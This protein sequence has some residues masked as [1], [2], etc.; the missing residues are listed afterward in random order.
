MGVAQAR[1]QARSSI[2]EQAVFRTAQHQFRTDL[3][4]RLDGHRPVLAVADTGPGIPSAEMGNVLKPFYRLEASRTT[5]GS[6]LGL[7]LVAAI[8]KQHRAELEAVPDCT[9]PLGR[10]GLSEE[11]GKFGRQGRAFLGDR[12]VTPAPF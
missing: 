9:G 10:S 7:N 4:V 8:A 1:L 11:P 5:E 3:Q 2:S 6:G 12:P